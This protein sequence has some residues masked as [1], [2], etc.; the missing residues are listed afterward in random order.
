MLMYDM[1][2]VLGLVGPYFQQPFDE[3]ADIVTGSTHKTYFGTQRGIAAVNF[4]E[5]DPRYEF[6]EAVQRRSFPGSLSNHHLGTLLGLLMAA[7]EMNHFRDAYQ[8]SIVANAKTF[9]RALSD[10]GLT[11]AGDP[12]ID[13]TET[14]QVILN[15]GFGKGPEIANRLEENNI[16]LN[17]QAAP[18][19]EGFTASGS[20]RMGVQEMTRFGME[21]D[22]FAE[23]AQLMTAVIVDGK[24]V[25]SD[26]KKLRSRFDRMRYC[27]TGKQIDDLMQQLHQVV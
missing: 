4:T 23:L 8:Q 20:L 13:F 17:Y 9:A 2:H 14:H 11:V 16:V 24:K 27:F 1:A 26:V 6:W 15:V 10:C 12:S 19:E 25:R 3:G 5:E 18:D 7:Y 22:D 21:P